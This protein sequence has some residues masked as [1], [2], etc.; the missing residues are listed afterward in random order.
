MASFGKAT[1]DSSSEDDLVINLTDPNSVAENMDFLSEEQ[2]EELLQKAKDINKRLKGQL[3]SE[4]RNNKQKSKDKR[5]GPNRNL[6]PF[7]P[8][9]PP[10]TTTGNSLVGKDVLSGLPH[11][12]SQQKMLLKTT[13]PR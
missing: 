6:N 11:D 7:L 3:S 13:Y 12:H 9:L 10:I 8:V 1:S 2:V 4:D 5:D